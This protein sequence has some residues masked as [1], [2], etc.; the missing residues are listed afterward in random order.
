MWY[1]ILGKEIGGIKMYFSK[2]KYTTLWQCPKAIWLKK[3]KP[4]ESVIDPGTIKRMNDGNIVGDLAMQLFGDYTEVTVYDGE[5]ID[6]SAM[7]ERTKE[8]LAKGTKQICEASF[9]YNGLYCAVDILK[10]TEDGYAI[11]EV[12]SSTC[13][14]EDEDK[15]PKEIYV[16]DV[17]YQR[18]V[19]TKCGINVTDTY[20]VLLNRDYVFDGELKLNELFNIVDIKDGVANESLIVEDNLKIAEELLSSEKEPDIDI[21]CRCKKP[22]MCSFWKYCS[23]HIPDYSVF[24]MYKMNFK[25][26]IEYYKRGVVSYEDLWNDGTI[27]NPTRILQLDHVLN[28]KSTPTINKEVI[29]EFVDTVRYPL[30]Y[31]DFETEQPVTPKYVGTHPYQQVPFQ[32][33]LHIQQED[34]SLEHKE[35]LAESG[36]DPRRTLAERLVNDIPMDVCVVA[37]NKTFECTRIK[38]LAEAF[39]DLAM[40]LLAIRENIIDLLIPFQHGGYYVTEMGGSFSIKSVLPALFPDDPALNYHNLDGVHN[41]S[42]AMDIFPKIKDMDA[43]ERE[44][45]R[46]NLLKY[47]GLDTYSMVVVMQKL[48]D[49]LKE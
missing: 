40:H 11:Y 14:E 39:P 31:L 45:T 47:C 22:Y 2:S 1:P 29:K 3:F 24:N 10:K 41:G 4:E 33:S 19:L 34:G 6:L 46:N 7:I 37:Y 8:E 28:K 26:K 23:K 36:P 35:F 49:A 17:A 21:D 15:D 13:S 12:K 20:L 18:Y 42:E 32:Y 43:E 5:K 27:N 48:I 9:E 38:E 30:Y 25:N 16:A 44:K